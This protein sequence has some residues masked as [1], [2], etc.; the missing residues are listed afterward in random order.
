[1]ANPGPD[2]QATNKQILREIR[3]HYSPAVGASEV[4][5]RIDVS[6]QTVDRH[7]RELADEGLVNTRKI[8][9][10]RVWW[11]SNDGRKR[12]DEKSQ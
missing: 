12:I 7:L 8:G 5:D 4:A 2:R 9:R 3:N 10:V 11:L 1:M 6:R